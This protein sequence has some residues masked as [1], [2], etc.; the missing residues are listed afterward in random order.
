MAHHIE[1]IMRAGAPAVGHA[2]S[3]VKKGKTVRAGALIT[4]FFPV[5]DPAH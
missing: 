5:W 4:F 2:V 3:T 1:E